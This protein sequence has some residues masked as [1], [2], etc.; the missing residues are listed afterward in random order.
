MEEMNNSSNDKFFTA[1]AR[2]QEK[3]GN[4]RQGRHLNLGLAAVLGRSGKKRR[5]LEW[6]QEEEG[7]RLRPLVK[8]YVNIVCRHSM[9]NP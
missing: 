4:E 8:A 7:C 9:S 2:K 3:V 6:E 1:I 5:C